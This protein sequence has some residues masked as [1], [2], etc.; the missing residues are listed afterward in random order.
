MVRRRARIFWHWTRQPSFWALVAL[1]FNA[2][3]LGWVYQLNRDTHELSK[4][5]RATIVALRK[6]ETKLTAAIE[7]Q[8]ATDAAHD[9][10]VRQF[11]KTTR[12]LDTLAALI[13][14]H[15]FLVDTSTC[16]DVSG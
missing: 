6:Q 15:F 1:L 8:C 14:L 3:L 12:N 7:H 2:F 16:K 11:L 5:N 10:A 4:E 13:G 9:V